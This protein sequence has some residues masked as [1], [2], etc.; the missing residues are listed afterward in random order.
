MTNIEIV[1]ILD[2]YSASKAD[3]KK[4]EELRLP[5]AVAWKR[6]VNLKR[7][8]RAREVIDEALREIDQRYADDQHS[9][10]VPAADGNRA[11]AVKKEYL[12]EYM[13]ERTDILMQDTDVTISAIKIGDLDGLSLSESDMDTIAFMIE[14]E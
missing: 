12:G 6:R 4:V 9:D 5:A 2:V 11:R 10:E 1:Q 13:R 14:E 8:I 7:L 3:N